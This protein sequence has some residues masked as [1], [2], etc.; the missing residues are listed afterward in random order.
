[1]N[2]GLFV[3]LR[4]NALRKPIQ[5]VR[6]R[7]H[8]QYI[9]QC[10]TENEIKQ[11]ITE[12]TEIVRGP[13]LTPEIS[14]RLFTVKCR[15]WTERP[16]LWPFADPF[17]A[18]YWPGGQALSRYLLNNP[19]LSLGR[20]VLDLGC[21]CGASAIAAKLSGAVHVVANDIDPIAA[22]ATKMNCELNSLE[23]CL[24]TEIDRSDQRTGPHLLVL[25]LGCGCG[26][27]AIAAKLSGAVHVVANDIDPIAAIATKM[28]CELNSLEPLPCV[29]ENLIG[30]EPENWDLILL[31]DMFYDETL[32]DSLH[33]WLYTC[34]KL[35]RTQILIGDP[36]RTQIESHYIRT[37]L[38]EQARFDLPNL[39]TEDNYSY[40]VTE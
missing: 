1:M 38:Y 19:E 18:I 8:R 21:G 3:C 14:L 32:T 27:S 33:K 25:D 35:H 39:V 26:A 34:F 37:L 28:N 11:F 15:F 9:T 16:E 17:W 22:I 5:S 40:L 7:S 36:G 6:Q 29:T 30:S 12:N 10:N 2:R 31:G 4:G 13:N 23:P 20:K 24:C